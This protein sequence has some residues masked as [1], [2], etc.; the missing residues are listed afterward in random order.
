LVY[1][2]VRLSGAEL[3]EGPESERN[4]RLR[5]RKCGGNVALH[6]RSLA[7]SRVDGQDEGFPESPRGDLRERTYI[8]AIMPSRGDV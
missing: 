2:G 5:P 1:Y 7:S 6:R 3:I 4:G 8:V